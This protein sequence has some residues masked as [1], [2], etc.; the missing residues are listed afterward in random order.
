MPEESQTLRFVQGQM[1]LFAVKI[2]GCLWKALII[3]ALQDCELSL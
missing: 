2:F 3:N 1:T